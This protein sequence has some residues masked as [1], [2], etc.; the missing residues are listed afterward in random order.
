MKPCRI[1]VLIACEESQIECIAFRELG[2]NAYSC[3]IQKCG[4]KHPEWHIL[5]DVSK[6]LKGESKFRTMDGRRHRLIKWHLII[7]H[8]PCTYLCKVSGVQLTKHG[9]RDETRWRK[10]IEARK[11]FYS[12]INAKAMFVAVENPIPLKVAELP[13]PAFYTCPS[14]FGHKYTKKTC[15][16]TSSLPPVLPTIYYPNPKSFV[17]CSRGKYRS[18]TFKNVAKEM[19]KQWGQFII[20][21]L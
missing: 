13:R 8:P 12:C 6:Y 5:D 17:H 4:G 7:A 11:F 16:W 20:D 18:R 9:V 10:M 2:F 21:N 14:Q 15:W 19:A 3:D 1:N